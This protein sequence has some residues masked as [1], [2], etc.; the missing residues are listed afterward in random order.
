VLLP[1][2]TPVLP[3]VGVP[4]PGCV[5]PDDVAVWDPSAAGGELAEPVLPGAPFEPELMTVATDSLCAVPGTFLPLPLSPVVPVALLFLL[6]C[7]VSFT[8]TALLAAE[9]AA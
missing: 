4:L 2:G 6:G 9:F 3:E 1:S 5:E 7:R 8:G